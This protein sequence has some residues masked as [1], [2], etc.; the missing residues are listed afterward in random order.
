MKLR[1]RNV[2]KIENAE[3]KLD[4]ITVIAGNND[5][6]K[7]TVGKTVFSLFNSLVDIDEKLNSQKEKLIYQMLRRE[8]DD[9]SMMPDGAYGTYRISPIKLRRCAR[10]LV[11]G[12]NR[13]AYEDI[14]YG[15]LRNIGVPTKS[16]VMDTVEEVSKIKSLSEERL[17]RSAVSAYFG[18][19]FNSEIN[20]AFRA[21]EEALVEAEIKERK[22]RMVFR[23]NNCLELQQQLNI[24]NEAVYLD[25]PFIVDCLNNGTSGMEG[26]ERVAV[27]KLRA[28]IN[29]VDNVVQ[30]SL[31][32]DKLHEV[33]D[34]I[35]EVSSGSV[36]C[37]ESRS[38]SYGDKEQSVKLNINNLSAGLKSFV[39]I[40]TLLEKGA[41]KEKDVL[42]LDEPEIHLHPA[43][44]MVYAEIIV[45]LQKCF[46]LTV[47][48]TTHSAH[49]LEALQYFAKKHALTERC[50]YYLSE[51]S[52]YGCTLRDVTVDTTEIY[53][54]LV[55]PSILLDKLR[56]ETE[57]EEDE[58][59]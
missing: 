35:S 54:Q 43:W 44:Q 42:I 18:Q 26:V 6:G 22:I 37:D 15:I 12:E 17:M 4:G 57:E 24:M 40:K 49:F 30:Y 53:A 5:T 39:I 27:H 28:A 50:N 48:L 20:N 19:I 3:L 46:D 36:T 45:L 33:L 51:N 9:L 31:I 7:S 52:R 58:S 1:I 25:N 59:L 21:E 41:L 32:E 56:Y 14:I 29:D 55:D 34:K 47:V 10:E 23:E 38:Y 8:M 16:M 13:E 11:E 2:G